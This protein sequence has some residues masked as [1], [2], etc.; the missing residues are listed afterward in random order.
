MQLL[1]RRITKNISL[2]IFLSSILGLNKNNSLFLIQKLGVTQSFK[3]NQL[4]IKGKDSLD[5]ARKALKLC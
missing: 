3:I 4:N 2:Y 5:I 1:G